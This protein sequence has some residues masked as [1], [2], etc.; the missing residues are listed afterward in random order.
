MMF[1]AMSLG[2]LLALL[3][4]EILLVY[5]FLTIVFFV[6]YWLIVKKAGYNGAWSLLFFV[7]LVNVVCLWVF[8]LAPWPVLER[9]GTALQ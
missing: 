9:R 6:P 5:A 2:V 8:A 3:S 7:P 1:L 4:P